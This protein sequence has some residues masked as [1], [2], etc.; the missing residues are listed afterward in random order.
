LVAIDL[1]YGTLAPV[2]FLG[3]I[4]LSVEGATFTASVFGETESLED[5]AGAAVSRSTSILFRHEE[6][7]RLAY[8]LSLERQESAGEAWHGRRVSLQAVERRVRS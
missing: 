1:V 4:Q 8:P 6:G 3:D 7:R 2:S 5:A